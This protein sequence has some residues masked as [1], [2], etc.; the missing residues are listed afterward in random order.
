MEKISFEKVKKWFNKNKKRVVAYGT[1][2]LVI[3][4][5]GVTA[6]IYKNNRITFLDWLKIASKEE[7][8]EIYEKLRLDF[9]K[10]GVKTFEMEKIS[11]ELGE[12]G[13]K[14]WF[15]KHPPNL[16]PNFRWT[17]INRWDKD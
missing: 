12:R 16:D 4:G 9:I 10:T 8:E 6:V 2:V 3:V 17:D 15:E 13:A 5:T 14:E 1:V 7:L 11:Q